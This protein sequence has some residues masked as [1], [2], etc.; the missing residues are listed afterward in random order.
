MSGAAPAPAP[1]ASFTDAGTTASETLPDHAPVMEVETVEYDKDP[2]SSTSKARLSKEVRKSGAPLGSV[3]AVDEVEAQAQDEDP[4]S[5]TSKA[6]LSKELRKSGAPLGSV[7]AV[8]E[9]EARAQDDPV[10]GFKAD[11]AVDDIQAVPAPQETREST[12]G[13]IPM[14]GPGSHPYNDAHDDFNDDYMDRMEE[15]ESDTEAQAQQEEYLI[16][17]ELVQEQSAPMFLEAVQVDPRMEAQPQE[18]DNNDDLENK[19]IYMHTQFRWIALALCAIMVIVV[20]A[21]VAVV[22]V[23]SEASNVSANQSQSAASLNTPTVAPTHSP[24]PTTLRPTA[25]PTDRPTFGIAPVSLSPISGTF[26]PTVD[27]P[28]YQEVFQRVSA[29]VDDTNMLQDGVSAYHRALD[30]LV[31]TD[32]I[33]PASTQLEQRYLLAVLYYSTITDTDVWRAC[34]PPDIDSSNVTCEHQEY[35]KQGSNVGLPQF[36]SVPSNKW[37]SSANECDWAGVRCRESAVDEIELRKL[38]FMIFPLG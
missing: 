22:L 13:A 4:P 30:W 24:N 35:I 25:A 36:T 16:Q 26:A 23:A 27:D 21:V 18:E 33:D 28:V 34:N 14:P 1:S 10:G 6:R 7:Y 5:S 20:V 31:F 8:D 37:L 17:A 32:D 12:P 9:V 29:V 38:C 19:P 11:G 2:S 3:Y 15:V